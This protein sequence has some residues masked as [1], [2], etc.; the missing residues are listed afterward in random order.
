MGIT[1]G[2]PT[3]AVDTST[4][5]YTYSVTVAP[6]A[7]L[8]LNGG[9]GGAA[10]RRDCPADMVLTG[11]AGDAGTNV[12]YYTP[13][14]SRIDITGSAPGGYAVSVTGMMS[15]AA[16]GTPCGGGGAAFDSQCPADAAVNADHGTSGV[17]LNSIGLDCVDI[18]IDFTPRC[19][20]DPARVLIYG[21]GGTGSQAHFPAG[22]VVTVASD[23]VW[24]GMTTADFGAFDV[25]WV[26]G[27][28]CGSPTSIFQTLLDTQGVWGPA[29]TGRMT[30]NSAD[31][32]L[33]APSSG[34]IPF[35]QNNV[36]WLAEGGATDEGGATGMY[37][38]WGCS[39]VFGG[40]TVL[41]G[42]FIP[43]FGAPLSEGTTLSSEGTI[44]ATGATHPILAGLTSAD[45]SW[46]QYAHGEFAT[47]PAGADDLVQGSAGVTNTFAI[48][49]FVC[50]P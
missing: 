37:F 8:P 18:E 32:D 19:N 6:G 40:P 25:I 41:P 20:T 33:H 48:D 49:N 50:V 17:F 2:T 14:C 47:I 39:L 42:D 36:S 28:N 35:I 43:T 45:L 15:L 13:T 26:D 7:D 9:A 10:Y 12:D 46:G 44:T 11:F 5:P 16:V 38:S 30:M 29:V 23:A 27:N 1:C 34:T 22:S 24:R 3:L 31:P 4:M 21:P